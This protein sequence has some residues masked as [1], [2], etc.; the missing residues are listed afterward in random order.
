MIQQQ[1]EILKQMAIKMDGQQRYFD[2]RRN[3]QLMSAIRGIQEE[4]HE[5]LETAVAKKKPWWKFW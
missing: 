1:N 4:K 3:Q 2:E 5:L